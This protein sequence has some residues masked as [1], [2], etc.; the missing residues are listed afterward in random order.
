MGRKKLPPDKFRQKPLRIRLNPEERRLVDEAAEAEGHRSTSAWARRG[1]LRLAEEVQSMKRK[2]DAE[3]PV[4][5]EAPEGGLTDLEV[6]SGHSQPKIGTL[7]FPVLGKSIYPGNT[8]L[9]TGVI[10]KRKP[11]LLLCA[12]WTVPTEQSLDA[13]I[14]VTRQVKTVVVV[15]TTSPPPVYIRITDGC[16]VSM[17]EQ[18]IS[19]REESDDES[20]LCGLADALPER[21]FTFCQR[22]AILLNCGEVMVV[23]GR[24][25]VEFHRSVPQ[26]LQ[27]AVRAPAAM[28]LNPTHTRMRNCG[29]VQAWRKYLSGGGRIYVS[30]SNWDVLNGQRQSDTLHSLWH[31]GVAATPT[32]IFE[33]ERLCYREWDMPLPADE[34]QAGPREDLVYAD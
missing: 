1:L 29:S 8:A 4:F 12:G 31:D 15:E 21:S 33:N 3:E 13:I 22:D 16:P 11:S 27:D 18:F 10:Q 20:L 25:H 23:Q 34:V 14:A 7:S 6:V 28:I 5:D 17:G 2:N 26:V 19:T 30:A 9:I 24:D 32:Y